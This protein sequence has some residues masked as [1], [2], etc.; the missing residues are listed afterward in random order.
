M[1]ATVV[2]KRQELGTYWSGSTRSR[3]DNKSGWD[4]RPT[5]ADKMAPTLLGRIDIF[6]EEA[7]GIDEQ[8][9]RQDVFPAHTANQSLKK[10]RIVGVVDVGP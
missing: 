4:S 1:S 2:C 10:G 7:T 5:K 3:T 6:V 8:L 9:V